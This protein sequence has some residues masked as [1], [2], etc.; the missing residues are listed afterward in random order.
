MDDLDSK[1]IQI[2]AYL[3]FLQSDATIQLTI[4]LKKM[5]EIKKWSQQNS[6]HLL[7]DFFIDLLDF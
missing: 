4:L 1:S 3:N 2:Q 7:N 6:N 5:F